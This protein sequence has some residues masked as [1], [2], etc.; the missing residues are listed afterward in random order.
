[1]SNHYFAPSDAQ[2]AHIKAITGMIQRGNYAHSLL[3]EVLAT[4]RF[5]Y[6]RG[7]I[8]SDGLELI[9][10]NWEHHYKTLEQDANTS[11]RQAMI[12]LAP[13]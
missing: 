4:I 11:A 7:H 12:G 6:D 9:L 8:E 10:A 5:N 1:M 2:E 3:G 13:R